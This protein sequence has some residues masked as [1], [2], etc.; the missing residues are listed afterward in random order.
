VFLEDGE[1]APVVLRH[2]REE[3]GDAVLVRL[4][5]EPGGVAHQHRDVA[6]DPVAEHPVDPLGVPG[7]APL[8]EAE[9]VARIEEAVLHRRSQESYPGPSGASTPGVSVF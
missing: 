1:E 7:A 2:D 5:R 9:E 6:L 8:E 3:L 4:P